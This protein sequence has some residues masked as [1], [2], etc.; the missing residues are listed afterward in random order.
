MVSSVPESG[1]LTRPVDFIRGTILLIPPEGRT[2]VVDE[3][4]MGFQAD[5][6]RAPGSGRKR[7]FLSV[8][9]S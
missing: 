9:V 3:G 7:N 1:G 5:S 2:I 6:E 4:R 8:I